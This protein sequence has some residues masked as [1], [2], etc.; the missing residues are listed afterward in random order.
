MDYVWGLYRI[1]GTDYS[2]GCNYSYLENRWNTEN[3]GAGRFYLTE[4]PSKRFSMNYG[5]WGFGN[6]TDLPTVEKML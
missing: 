6:G 1:W 2:N 5:A 3:G 4:S